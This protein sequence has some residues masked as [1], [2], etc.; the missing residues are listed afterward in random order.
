MSDLTTHVQVNLKYFIEKKH[1]V[2]K[3]PWWTAVASE[4]RVQPTVRV[5]LGY[6]RQQMA[7]CLIPQDI[8]L[9]HGLSADVTNVCGDYVG[10]TEGR[11]ARV[12]CLGEV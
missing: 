9:N 3:I 12:G 8:K 4:R 7:I 5:A 2:C 11:G 1:L 10:A 6:I